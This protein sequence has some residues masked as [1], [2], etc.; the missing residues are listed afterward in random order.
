MTHSATV[1][2]VAQRALSAIE[3]PAI[4]PQ[5]KVSVGGAYPQIRQ[6]KTDDKD[7][8][9]QFFNGLSD[10][11][12]FSRFMTPIS[13][14]SS[15]LLRIL[16]N[17]DTPSHFAYL[18]TV[19]SGARTKM[20]GEA[21]FVTSERNPRLA[22]FAVAVADDWQGKG[23]ASKLMHMIEDTART[24]GVSIIVGTALRSNTAMIE[25][26]RH[27]G[28]QLKPDPSEAR[29]VRLV[30]QIAALPSLH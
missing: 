5:K 27:L 2:H 6:M 20:V 14:I 18:A 1:N 11:S 15:S 28:Y 19:K 23:L 8:L 7:L 12:R 22:E 16:S 24:Q 25:L 10:R 21:R 13:E 4:S 30:K 17:V 26:A 29:A 9:K 3:F